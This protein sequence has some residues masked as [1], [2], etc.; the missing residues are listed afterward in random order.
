MNMPE[1][2]DQQ[3]LISALCGYWM[4]SRTPTRMDDRDVWPERERE[5]ESQGIPCCQT[6]LIMLMLYIG[7][8]SKIRNIL[9]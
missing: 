3:R 7:Y 2:A 1:L 6:K 4:H 5:K 8:R 9:V